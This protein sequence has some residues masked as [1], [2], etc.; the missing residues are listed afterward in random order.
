MKHICRALQSHGGR[1]AILR[2]EN[3]KSG[4]LRSTHCLL[5]AR[6]SGA[7][8]RRPQSCCMSDHHAHPGNLG[9]GWRRAEMW[10]FQEED[11]RLYGC[12]CLQRFK[13]FATDLPLQEDRS[14]QTNQFLVPEAGCSYARRLTFHKCP[15]AKPLG[16]NKKNHAHALRPLT[17]HVHRRRIAYS[18]LR[19]DWRS[20][21]SEPRSARCAVGFA[22]HDSPEPS[23]LQVLM[24]LGRERW[25]CRSHW[26]LSYWIPQRTR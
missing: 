21:E 4:V 8:C 1:K 5:R 17:E 23:V 20:T 11:V 16:P 13:P 25:R 24:V 12:N 9:C 15:F 18:G 7:R 10:A 14:S 22:L 3:E 19:L 2:H 6:S 26:I